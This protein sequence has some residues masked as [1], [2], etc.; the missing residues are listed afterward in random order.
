MGKG[1]D[2]TPN[3]WYNKENEAKEV[4]QMNAEIKKAIAKKQK[5]HPVRKWW[6]KNGYKVMRVV[7]FPVWLY[8]VLTDKVAAWLN[9]RQKWS[10]ERA[11]QILSYYIPRRASWHEETKTFHFFDNGMGWNIGSAKKF[12]K[13]KDRRFWHNHCGFGGYRIREYLINCFELEGFEKEVLD[14]T[15]GWTGITFKLIEEKA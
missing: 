7:L 6:G 10:N 1:V 8:I 3:P 14:T 12:L 11:D 4:N 13:M 5:K 2:K 15:D 9:S